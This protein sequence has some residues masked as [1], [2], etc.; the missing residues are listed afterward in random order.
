MYQV[1]SVNFSLFLC[2]FS[3]WKFLPMLSFQEV[4]VHPVELPPTGSYPINEAGLAAHHRLTPV[5]DPWRLPPKQIQQR[6][7]P[8]LPPRDWIELRNS[9]S[10]AKQKPEMANGANSV[11]GRIS[12]SRPPP[13]PPPT[14]APL[15]VPPQPPPKKVSSNTG[16]LKSATPPAPNP[17]SNSRVETMSRNKFQSGNCCKFCKK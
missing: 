1:D 12:D 17:S 6:L 7:G 9:D 3:F 8:G 13:P 15:P 14:S 16:P 2:T 10:P 11:S 4:A 5:P